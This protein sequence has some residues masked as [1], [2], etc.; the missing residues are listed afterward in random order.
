MEERVAHQRHTGCGAQVT[1]D[2]AAGRRGNQP[3]GRLVGREGRLRCTCRDRRSRGPGWATVMRHFFGFGLP[4]LA[5]PCLTAG[6]HA[7]PPERLLVAPPCTP[8]ALAPCLVPTL[9]GAVPVPP[10]APG[11]QVDRKVTSVAKETA[12]VWAGAIHGRSWPGHDP[13]NLVILTPSGDSSSGPSGRWLK[14]NTRGHLP[15]V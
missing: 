14:L 3:G 9:L 5:I 2:E 15:R 10:I 4:A 13:P 11:A 6:V 1:G 8:Q 7:A 12:A